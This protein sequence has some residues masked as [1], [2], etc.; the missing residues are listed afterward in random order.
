LSQGHSNWSK[1]DFFLFI[2]QCETFG[3]ADYEKIASGFYNKTAE[4]I[5]KYSEIFWKKW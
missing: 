5:R 2:R 3:R 1:K 4:E